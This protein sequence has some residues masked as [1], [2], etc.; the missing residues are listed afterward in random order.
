MLIQH[1]AEPDLIIDDL[2]NDDKWNVRQIKSF[3]FHQGHASFAMS[4]AKKINGKTNV[5]LV[6]LSQGFVMK[7]DTAIQIVLNDNQC[8]YL[9]KDSY[10]PLEQPTN[11]N[12][13]L[14]DYYTSMNC[15]NNGKK[16]T[17][18]SILT[19]IEE[20]VFLIHNCVCFEQIRNQLP[21][22]MNDI[23]QFDYVQNMIHWSNQMHNYKCNNLPRTHHM[24]LPCGPFYQ[25]KL[26]STQICETCTERHNVYPQ[27]KW[28]LKWNCNVHTNPHCFVWDQTNG[29]VM[30]M[31]KTCKR[32]KEI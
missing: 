8:A 4:F 12:S 29:L 28:T 6:K 10:W 22:Q 13:W 20:P 5:C 11:P 2:F 24:Q 16:Q 1:L 7:F 9:C 19:N 17:G 23:N 15:I 3:I 31:M 27:H 21:P 26:H 30:T 18:W 25:C 32:Y 14:D